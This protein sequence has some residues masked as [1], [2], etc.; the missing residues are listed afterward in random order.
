MASRDI[1][2]LV[3]ELKEKFWKF[4]EKA[5]A[6]GIL[7]IVTCISRSILEQMALYVQGRLPVKDVNRF[8]EVAGL[9]AIT[10]K[11]NKKVTWTLSSKH[12]T[13]MFDKD[14]NNDLSRAFDIV[15]IKDKKAVWNIKAD[16]NKNNI[17]DYEELGRIG[18]KLGL[19]WGGRWN[20]PDF[21]HFQIKE[22]K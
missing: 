6:K 20:P 3:P 5:E 7:F 12:V 8:R 2:K 1:N 17:P 11:Q 14:L 4:K 22:N 13:N 18:E 16:I 19:T 15:L 21:A 10:T 9:P